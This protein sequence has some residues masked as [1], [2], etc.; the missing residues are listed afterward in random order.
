MGYAEFPDIDL[1][2]TSFRELIQYYLEVRDKY[3]GTLQQ[4]TETNNRLTEY[5]KDVDGRING[6]VESA[7]DIY[8]GT[9][10]TE[11]DRRFSN[12][13]LNLNRR[14][15]EIVE[16]QQ[17]FESGVNE[18]LDR[19]NTD[20]D[21][22]KNQMNR[23][24]ESLSHMVVDALDAQDTK[25][26]IFKEQMV[27]LIT[28]YQNYVDAKLEEIKATLP[29]EIQSIKW[30]WDNVFQWH[31]FNCYEWYN[32][33][34]VTCEEWNRSEITCSEWYTDGKHIFA[35]YDNLHKFF[36]PVSGERVGASEAVVELAKYLKINSMTAGEYD[37]LHITA[38]KYDCMRT[39]AG[40]YDWSG[41]L[42]Y[43]QFDCRTERSD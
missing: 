35:W 6:A 12:I 18:E 30:L 25:I 40:D 36:S 33:N 31:G 28:N 3:N 17:I 15:Q 20:I 4:I 14:V 43:N 8:K 13:E 21:S 27:T 41:E 38:D 37:S 16:Q 7:I 42:L 22:Y 19:M 39:T 5:E 29:L 10:Q 11:M 23:R 9:V 24:F 2:D 1:S 34:D 26:D 32:Y